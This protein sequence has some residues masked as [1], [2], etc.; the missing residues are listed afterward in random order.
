MQP[1]II[2]TKLEIM[3]RGHPVNDSRSVRKGEVGK[4]II[5]RG[6]PSTGGKH[7]DEAGANPKKI[8]R[9]LGHTKNA[10]G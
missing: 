4:G 9:T 7:L 8:A 3:H 6:L 1:P 5:F 10:D 2:S